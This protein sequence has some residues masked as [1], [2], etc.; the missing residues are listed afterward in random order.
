MCS[1]GASNFISCQRSSGVLGACNIASQTTSC[2]VRMPAALF[3]PFSELLGDLKLHQKPETLPHVA[4]ELQAF[5][6]ITTLDY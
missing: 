5:R 3:G 6:H 4:A 2:P 1:P